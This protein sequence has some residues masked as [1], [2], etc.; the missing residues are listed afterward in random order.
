M[1]VTLKSSVQ[2]RLV[3][4]KTTMKKIIFITL[5]ILL[6]NTLFAQT[7]KE[8]VWSLIV[9]LDRSLVAKD[10]VLLNEILTEDFIG[11]VPTGMS[12]SKRNYIRFHCQPKGGLVSIKSGEMQDATVRFYG[13]TSI[14]NRKVAAQRKGPDGMMTDLVVQRIEVCIMEKGKWI[15]AAGQGTQVA[16]PGTP[17]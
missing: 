17:R 12:Y 3:N 14:V 8:R 1:C 13:N 15:I 11:A 7:E 4:N 9:Q 10:S 2:V 6:T 5:T 16:V